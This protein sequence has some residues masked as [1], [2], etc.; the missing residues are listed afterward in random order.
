MYYV[1]TV[2]HFN[3]LFNFDEFMK[4]LKNPTYE[5][6]LDVHNFKSKCNE[7]LFNAHFY[8][9]YWDGDIRGRDI[10][11]GG[12]PYPGFECELNIIL[13]WKQD[14]N[15]STFMMSPFPLSCFKA[16]IPIP[17]DYKTI[18]KAMTNTE[19][20]IHELFSPY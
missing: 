18:L 1:G 5:L 13:L 17:K 14:N 12:I 4:K 20:L 6:S 3:G 10:Y 7:Y 15:G 8:E 16:C 2:D 9:S 11:V 19:K